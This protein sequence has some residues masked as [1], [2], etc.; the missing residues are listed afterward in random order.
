MIVYSKATVPRN[1]FVNSHGIGGNR[2]NLTP[3]FSA[4]S[5]AGYAR[6]F[7]PLMVIVDM[8]LR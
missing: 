5:P 8:A 7:L 2:K 6:R 1:S 4:Q 3:P